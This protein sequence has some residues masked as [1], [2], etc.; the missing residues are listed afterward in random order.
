[1]KTATL[2]LISLTCILSSCSKFDPLLNKI[3][4]LPYTIA[5]SPDVDAE[6]KTTNGGITYSFPV[7]PFATHSADKLGAY[8][9]TPARVADVNIDKLT[10][11]I[12][13]D[14]F[15]FADKLKFYVSTSTLPEVLVGTLDEVPQDVRKVTFNCTGNNIKQYYMADTIYLRLEARL[16]EMPKKKYSYSTGIIFA[17]NTVHKSAK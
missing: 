9:V 16:V 14:D 5:S 12:S 13:G 2:T 10:Q 7:V 17:V 3:Y 8:G 11:T 4:E 1:M 6:K 15:S